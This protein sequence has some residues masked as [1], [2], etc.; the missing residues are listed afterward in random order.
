MCRNSYQTCDVALTLTQIYVTSTQLQLAAESDFLVVIYLLKT[1][2]DPGFTPLVDLK[3]Y[4]ICLGSL[5]GRNLGQFG[6]TEEGRELTLQ[7][8]TW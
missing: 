4:I 8:G 1:L 5:R 3:G 6:G 7:D 2:Y